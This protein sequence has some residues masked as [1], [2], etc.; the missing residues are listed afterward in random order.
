LSSHRP[1]ARDGAKMRELYEQ[2]RDAYARADY[3]VETRGESSEVVQAILK[4]PI[5]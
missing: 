4:L 1:L 3:R 2:R 5:F